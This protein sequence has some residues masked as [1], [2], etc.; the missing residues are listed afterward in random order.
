MAPSARG[1]QELEA[2]VALARRFVEQR[3]VPEATELYRVAQRLDPRNL[4][5][6]LA[7]AQLRRQQHE[8]AGTARTPHEQAR[9]EARRNV[10]DAAHF[11]GL[12]HLYT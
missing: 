4:G 9:E 5:V 6:Q 3:R 12:A 1:P 11:L 8:P 10:I 2:L 7:L